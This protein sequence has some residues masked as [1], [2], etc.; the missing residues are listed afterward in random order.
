MHF[1]NPETLPATYRNRIL[2]FFKLLIEEV[3]EKTIRGNH[4]LAAGTQERNQAASQIEY[5]AVAETPNN[6]NQISI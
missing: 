3:S 5:K 6:E 4:W 1:T 2:E